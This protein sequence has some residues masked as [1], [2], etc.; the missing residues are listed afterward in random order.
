MQNLSSRNAYTDVTVEFSRVKDAPSFNSFLMDK[1][2]NDDYIYADT[3]SK[4]VI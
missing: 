1:Y 2:L 4:E 3:C